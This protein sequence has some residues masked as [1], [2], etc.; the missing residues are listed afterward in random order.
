MWEAIV[1]LERALLLNEEI[2]RWTALGRFHRYLSIES[3]ALLATEKALDS[4]PTNLAALE[5]RAAILANTGRFDE[6]L[7]VINKRLELAAN[8]W[9]DAVKAYVLLRKG[10]WKSIWYRDLRATCYRKLGET[11]LAEEDHRWI[12]SRYDP[13]NDNDQSYFAGAAYRLAMADPSQ[14]DRGLMDRA[15]EINRKLLDDPAQDSFSVYCDL[16]AYSLASGDLAEGEKYFDEAI[17]RAINRRQV[18]D[19]INFEL[20]T[21]EESLPAWRHGAQAREVLDRVKEKIE[22]RKIELEKPRSAEAE[23]ENEVAK[24]E[25][26]GKNEGWAWV[27]AK[28]GLARLYVADAR[29]E[30]AARTYQLLLQEELERFPEARAGLSNALNNIQLAGDQLLKEGKPAEAIERFEQVLGFSSETPAEEKKKET[31]L[32][33][34]IAYA[35]FDLKDLA[36]ARANFTEAL[37][38]FRE[39]GAGDPGEALGSVC[40]SLLGNA[41]QYWALDDEWKAF[42]STAQKDERLT[43]ELA[44][45]RKSLSHFLDELYQLSPQSGKSFQML[46]VV[47]PIAV[48]IENSLAPEDAENDWSLIKNDIPKMRERIQ[49]DM[50]VSVPGVRIRTNETDLLYGSY[51]IMLDEVPLVLGYVRHEMRYCPES[52]ATLEAL[53]IPLSDL[54]ESLHPMTGEQGCWVSADH[55]KLVIGH[56]LELWEEPLIFMLYHLEAVLRRNLADFLGVQEVEDFIENWKQTR[57]GSSLIKEALPDQASRIRLVWLLQALVKEGVPIT[58]WEE[59][60]EEVKRVGL[61]SDDVSETLR[62]VRLRLKDYLPGNNL[63]APRMF[64]PEEIEQSIER[65]VWREGGKTFLALTPEETQEILSEI[66]ELIGSNSK[67]LILVTRSAE[68]RPVIRRLVELEFPDLVVTSIE[69]LLSQEELSEAPQGI[70]K[71]QTKGAENDA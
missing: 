71:E 11:S 27:G 37:Q 29:W 47:T 5:E 53:G 42:E 2:Y 20:K 58:Y 44:A 24:L 14:I 15:I 22:T 32:L 43:G 49:N 9:V 23:L 7:E 13:S 36:A 52:Q 66:R 48:E 40:R 51:I 50:G 55:W 25:A 3:N 31:E 19:L 45:A 65:G 26:Q 17:A 12:W 38:L 10:E 16:A 67:K 1:Y 54:E 4:S 33:C 69:E 21:L 60:L 30:E 57:R 28:A 64:L 70:E 41:A 61:S 62:A 6:A 39:N 59:I 34:R 63:A 68:L 8:A 56:G 18:D 46:P 35:R